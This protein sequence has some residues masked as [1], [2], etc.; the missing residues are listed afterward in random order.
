MNIKDLVGVLLG[1]FAGGKTKKL[2]DALQRIQ[3]VDAQFQAA[4]VGG[5]VE[6]VLPGDLQKAFRGKS[7]AKFRAKRAVFIREE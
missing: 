4:E 1:L 6:V 7:G 5:E 2:G 3:D